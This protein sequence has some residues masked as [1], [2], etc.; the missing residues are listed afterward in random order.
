M[1]RFRD[2]ADDVDTVKRFAGDVKYL[3]KFGKN[4]YSTLFHPYST[5]DKFKAYKDKLVEEYFSR[6]K[7]FHVCYIKVVLTL[8]LTL[9]LGLGLGLGLG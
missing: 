7:V 1:D 9:A 4:I 6:N 5:R 8:T 3:Y 2:F